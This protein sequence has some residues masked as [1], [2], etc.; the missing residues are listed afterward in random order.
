MPPRTGFTLIETLVV[1]GVLTLMTSMLVLYNRTG[2]RQI[3][4][5]REKARLISTIFR[6]KSLALNTLIEDEPACGYGVHIKEKQYFIYR[7]KAIACRTSDHVYTENADEMVTGSVVH[8]DAGLSFSG[9]TL[10]DIMFVPPNPKVFLNGGQGLLE[11]VMMLGVRDGTSSV[12]IH[13]NHAGQIS[14]E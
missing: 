7:D 6:A 13:I 10:T 14:A 4:L 5:L 11:G 8:I 2:E 3:I 9:G 12:T 1:L